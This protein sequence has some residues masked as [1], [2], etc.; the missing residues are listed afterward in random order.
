[1]VSASLRLISLPS[2]KRGPTSNS[3]GTFGIS[4]I[5]WSSRAAPSGSGTPLLVGTR[6]ALQ[7]ISRERHDDSS[8]A[9]MPVSKA[10]FLWCQDDGGFGSSLLPAAMLLLSPPLLPTLF[11]CGIDGSGLLPEW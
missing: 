2:F 8:P 7:D 6:T 4:L 1:M 9:D 10:V 5:V 3:S 11:P